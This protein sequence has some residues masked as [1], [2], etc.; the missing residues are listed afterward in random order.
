MLNLAISVKATREAYSSSIKLV[1]L[2]ELISAVHS[3]L[4]MQQVVKIGQEIPETL[5]FYDHVIIML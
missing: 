1:I 5:G 4:I 2:A 3:K